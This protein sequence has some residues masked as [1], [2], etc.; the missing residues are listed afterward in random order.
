MRICIIVAFAFFM[1][2]VRECES[3]R[4]FRKI[5]KRDSAL[6]IVDKRLTSEEKDSALIEVVSQDHGAFVDDLV[7]AFLVDATFR[8]I[9]NIIESTRFEEF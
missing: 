1:V 8:I 7:T 3:F 6:A 5:K 9:H 4:P 2:S